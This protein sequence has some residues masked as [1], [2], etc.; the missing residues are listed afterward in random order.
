MDR[1]E[2]RKSNVAGMKKEGVTERNANLITQTRCARITNKT[3]ANTEP[4]VEI[5]I[6][7]ENA[8]F[9]PPVTAKNGNIAT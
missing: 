8:H 9:G 1:S 4:I 5:T 6:R 3:N 2:N 7:K